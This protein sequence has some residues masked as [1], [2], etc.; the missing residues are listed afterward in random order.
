MK[1]SII[2]EL[3]YGN[4]GTI[5]LIENDANYKLLFN[6]S[7]ELYQQIKCFLTKNQKILFEEFCALRGSLEAEGCATHYTEG[8]KIGLL[9]GI[10]SLDIHKL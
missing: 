2:K 10:E 5:N 7:F 4:C 9:I 3:F 1:Q 8:F 6:K